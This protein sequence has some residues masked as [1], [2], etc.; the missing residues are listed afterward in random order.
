MFWFL[1][2]LILHFLSFAYL[3]LLFEFQDVSHWVVLGFFPFQR[4]HMEK[5]SIIAST[6]IKN[7]SQALKNY[8]ICIKVWIF[9]SETMYL[10][11]FSMHLVFSM[12]TSHFFK[13]AKYDLAREALDCKSPRLEW[14]NQITGVIQSSENLNSWNQ[15]PGQH[16]AVDAMDQLKWIC[17]MG[18]RW[19]RDCPAQTWHLQSS[20]PSAEIAQ[21]LLIVCMKMKSCLLGGMKWNQCLGHFTEL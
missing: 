12:Y 18:D 15:E 1:H 13:Q 7:V 2:S 19:D 20:N 14:N 10:L 11:F 6:S 4:N 16:R 5:N 3:L 8:D 9:P 21:F 17:S